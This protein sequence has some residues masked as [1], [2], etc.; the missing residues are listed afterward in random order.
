M[1]EVTTKCI[2]NDRKSHIDLVHKHMVAFSTDQHDKIDIMYLVLT[3]GITL[4]FTASS[5]Y[6]KIEEHFLTLPV[7]NFIDTSTLLP[8]KQLLAK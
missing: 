8:A 4:K 5:K 3:L 6:L 2:S 1:T 7:S